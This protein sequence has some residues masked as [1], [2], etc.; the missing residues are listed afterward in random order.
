MTKRD[1][2]VFVKAFEKM[3]AKGY[4]NGLQAKCKTKPNGKATLVISK[5]GRKSHQQKVS[6]SVSSRNVTNKTPLAA[7]KK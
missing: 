6:A 7:S 3:K 4:F 1:E 2:A 5:I